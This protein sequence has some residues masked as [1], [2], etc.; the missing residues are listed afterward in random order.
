MTRK[1]AEIAAEL[2]VTED[3]VRDLIA[4]LGLRVGRTASKINDDVAARVVAKAK[5]QDAAPQ[6]P[7]AAGTGMPSQFG[8]RPMRGRG[9][10]AAP[11]MEQRPVAAPTAPKAI[12]LPERLTVKELAERLHVKSTAVIAT[13]MSS[14]VL[15]TINDV[16]DYD[17]GA[18]VA[19]ELGF[20][21]S[22]EALQDSGVIDQAQLRTIL[23]EE[24]DEKQIPRPPVIAVIG[25]VDHGKTLL[26]DT[27]RGTD[28]ISREAGGIT[29]GIGASQ[30]V[31][32]GRQITL[33][34]TPGHEAFSAMRAR[35][36]KTTD[37]AILVVAA[38]DGVKE[39]TIEAIAHATGAG[40]PLVV[41]ITKVDKPESNPTRVK[42]QLAEHGIL[43][44]GYG[45][46]IPVAEVS[47]KQ[48]RGIDELLDL[49]L[50][51]ADMENLRADPDRAAVASVIESHLD[52]N[53]GPVASLLV[54][55]GT[56]HL[57]DTFAVGGTYG[58][59]KLMLG[60]GRV[61][62]TSAGPSVPALVAGFAQ[63][64]R[65]GDVLQVM[66]TEHEAREAALSAATKQGVADR[67]HADVSAAH[68]TEE[69]VKKD[70][71]RVVVKGDLRGSLEAIRG[72]LE[73]LVSDTIQVKIVHMGV[74]DVTDSD[75]L[76][77]SA[78]RADIY[79]F[80]VRIPVAMVR[81]A[82]GDGIRLKS[83]NVI[84][85]LVDD[86][87]AQLNSLL[88]PERVE[89]PLG[90]M[91]ILKIFFRG[92][93]ECVAGGD[94]TQGLIRPETH[95]R[96]YRNENLLGEGEISEVHLGPEKVKEAQQGRQCGVRFL[97]NLRIVEGD[98]LDVSKV[99]F[100]ERKV[101]VARP[102]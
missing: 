24:A 3:K 39:Q 47:A 25:H 27:I 50:L 37:I 99:E 64:P 98:I 21:P 72:A 42:Q 32:K 94:V 82:E 15:A 38:D 95:A 9:G 19:G 11:E 31:H 78:A 77:A 45:G 59:V 10:R 97:G 6:G 100:R 2:G 90:K 17:T 49:I 51:V 26:L 28:V 52:P 60:A 7:R 92:K 22:P 80:N 33:L 43:V 36:V 68:A 83:F 34:D 16:I 14:G 62:L 86:I 56:L 57:R 12:D 61:H 13:L 84:Y 69:G 44:E 58:R 41:A 63:V 20:E 40:V 18:I 66:P 53:L 81:R 74:G 23:A 101:T 88:E 102:G 87:E 55:A 67:V 71:Y 85:Q 79:A 70:E 96:V 1:V 75:L 4:S 30:V 35:G 65:A 5:G 91:R 29:Q 8:R 89:T 76:L 48:K 46:N 54:H 93:G 73:R